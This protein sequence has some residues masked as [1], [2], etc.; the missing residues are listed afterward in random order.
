[1][2]GTPGLSPAEVCADLSDQDAESLLPAGALN[3]LRILEPAALH[4]DNRAKTLSTMLSIPLAVDD[5]ERRAILLDQLVK[6]KVTD[7]EK[8]VGVSLDSLRTGELSATHRREVLGFFGYSGAEERI[9][10]E[11]SDVVTIAPIHGLFPHQKKAASEIEKF[12]YD[13]DRRAMLHLPT[14]VGKTRTAMSVVAS[15]LR[16]HRSRLVVWLATTQ[17]LLEQAVNEFEETWKAVGDKDV[18]L[19]RFWD[20]HKP[21]IDDIT[22]GLLFASLAKLHSYGKADLERIWRLGNHASMV[23]F[24]EAH[25]AV[26]PTYRALVA[27]L[28]TRK[29]DTKLLGL[30]ATPGRSWDNPEVD[31]QVAELFAGNKVTLN[32]GDENP[33]QHLIRDG[34]LAD[35][36]FSLLNVEPGFDFSP[37]DLEDLANAFDLPLH[38]ANALGDDVTR[39][40]RILQKLLELRERHSRIIVFA[41]SVQNAQLL[42]SVCR[43]IDL[44]AD[45]ITGETDKG[46]R[47][48]AI[49]RFKAHGTSCRVLINFGVL[50]TGFDA[51]TA[52]A[53]LIA[54]PTKSLV[55][56]SQMVGRVIRG[57]KAG[58]DS[59]CEVVTVVDTTLPGFRDVAEAFL[60]W[61][62]IW[63]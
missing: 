11:R 19:Y 51:P 5:Q 1:M 61:E 63:S 22:D 48:R 34:Y 56:F 43:A 46:E 55:L 50:T 16:S 38:L 4:D 29:P 24:D 25:Q 58:G 62:D 31:E 40:L 7:L 53:A 8:R 28:S 52:S 27:T 2:Q 45:T 3:L 60:N 21:P 23:V 17:E 10:I 15:H 36:E 6:T 33:I 26:A 35:T 54:R 41:T 49:R 37:E 59:T 44:Q 39:N 14:G 12:L 30:S 9:Q 13:S 18:S 20:E 42:G 32:F 57:P 47:Q